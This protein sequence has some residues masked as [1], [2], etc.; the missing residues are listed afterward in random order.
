MTQHSGP[1]LGDTVAAVG[2]S[3]RCLRLDLYLPAASVGQDRRA[4]GKTCAVQLDGVG[5]R[6][7]EANTVLS[8]V[9]QDRTIA[10]SGK[11]ADPP[12]A[13]NPNCGG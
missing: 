11:L 5:R 12:T 7:S 8:D 13:A 4:S 9:A 1:H 6:T 10:A 3:S 2:S